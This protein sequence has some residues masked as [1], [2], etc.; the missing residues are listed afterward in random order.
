MTLDIILK[1]SKSYKEYQLLVNE[2]LLEG[3]T[4]GNTQTETLVAFTKLNVQR[5]Q[6][7]DKTITIP[8]PLAKKISEISH[9]CIWL[10]IGDAWCGDCAQIAPIINKIAEQG[11][12][13]I[14]FKIISRDT[15]PELVEKYA[16]NGTKAIPKLL[17]INTPTL[18]VNKVWGP[19]PRPAQQIMLNWKLN[20]DKIT[21]ED[22]EKQLHLWYSK[23]KGTTTINELLELI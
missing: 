7:L 12:N 17:I 18:A 4:T 15:Y 21:R 9:P 2:L 6:R 10:M 11:N 5:M 16:T 3:K 13:K 23:D 14:D 8:N 19:R 22:F 1:E 20:K